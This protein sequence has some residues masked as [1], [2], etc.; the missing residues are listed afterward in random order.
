M[1]EPKQDQ[2][3]YTTDDVLRM[4]DTPTGPTTW[5]TTQAAS[6][7]WR[8]TAARTTPGWWAGL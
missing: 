5:S 1:Q 2:F 8:H 4:L 7:I 6:I 3:I